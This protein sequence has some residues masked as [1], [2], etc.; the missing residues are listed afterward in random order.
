ME[1]GVSHLQV[2]PIASD[3]RAEANISRRQIDDNHLT[4]EGF[5]QG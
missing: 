4:D 5:E 1:I 2:L 3:E